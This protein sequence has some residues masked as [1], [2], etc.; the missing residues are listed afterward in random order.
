MAERVRPVH[1]LWVALGGMC[2]AL[3][4]HLTNLTIIHLF[5]AS[6]YFWATAFEN[7]FGSFLMGFGFVLL[8]RRFPQN[9][10]LNLFLLTGLIGSYTTYSGFGVQGITLLAESAGIF[11]IY[12]FG[13]IL[14]GLILLL[15]GM[16]CASVITSFFQ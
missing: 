3:M 16:K 8:S 2:G 1:F 10:A 15:F 6:S 7:I 14:L 11:M 12:F 13:Q 4:R 9:R 5:G